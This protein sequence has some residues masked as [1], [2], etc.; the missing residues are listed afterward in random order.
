MT[1]L[2]LYLQTDPV[3]LYHRKVL[4]FFTYSTHTVFLSIMPVIFQPI[5]FNILLNFFAEL[6]NFKLY[7]CHSVTRFQSI[8]NVASIIQPTAK[9]CPS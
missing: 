4:Y 7:I 3:V 8:N 5:L 9:P 6:L 2:L 1:S